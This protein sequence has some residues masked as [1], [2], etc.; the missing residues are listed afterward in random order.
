[1]AEEFCFALRC[2]GAGQRPAF[3]RK[4]SQCANATHTADHCLFVT[5]DDIEFA[6]MPNNGS[7]KS[8]LQL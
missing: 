5:D 3:K 6:H 4:C 2:Q 1:M 8:A 7:S